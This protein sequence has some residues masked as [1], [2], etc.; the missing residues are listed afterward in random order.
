M[1]KTEV[2]K[3]NIIQ[4]A[5]SVVSEEGVQKA[6]LRAIAN[7]A[8]ISV[9][10][11]YYYYKTKDDLLY[12]LVNQNTSESYVIAQELKSGS[13]KM[14]LPGEQT[15]GNI[16]SYIMEKAR[17]RIEGFEDNKIFFYLAQE[18]IM[19]NEA[20]RKKI[21]H[22]YALWD[23][24]LEDIFVEISR[25][26]KSLT[27]RAAAIIINAALDGFMLRSLLGVET[28]E[29]VEKELDS[30]GRLLLSADS[31]GLL[32]KLKDGKGDL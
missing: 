27:T 26:P 25:L 30:M 20:M 16:T 28:D 10:A 32:L 2:A 13:L 9:G 8:G 12:D 4:A 17:E 3:N 24:A 15:A 29:K 19:G 1:D 11:L 14:D 7:R 23:E 31:E 22:K 21:I 5:A 18:A 6:T